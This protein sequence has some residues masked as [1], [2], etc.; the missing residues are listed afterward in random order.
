MKHVEWKK[1]I[2]GNGD[3]EFAKYIYKVV[4]DLMKTSLDLGTMVSS[5]ASKLRAYKEQVKSAHNQKWLE[6]AAVLEFF[7]LIQPCVCDDR[8]FCRI[9]GGSRF[10]LS[11]TL[12]ISE[13][14]E[15]GFIASASATENQVNKLES[16]ANHMKELLNG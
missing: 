9:C 13:L 11:D 8:E 2:D 14:H 4:N 12:K 10:I 7:E 6:I 15:V 5:D 1:Y 16:H 3:F